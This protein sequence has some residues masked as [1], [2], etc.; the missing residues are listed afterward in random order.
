[1]KVV[2][3]VH[4]FPPSY[5]GGAEWETYRIASALQQLGHELRVICVERIDTGPT[6][7]VAWE[8]G[9]YGGIRVRRLVFNLAAMP[10]PLRGE[11]DNTWIGDHLR[12]VFDEFRPDIF[13][14]MGGYL[15]SGRAI[16][17]AN[18]LGIATVVSLMDF[19]FL[20]RRITLLRS[21]G[22]LSTLPVTSQACARCLGEERRRFRWLGQI[23]PALADVYWR[24]Q[25]AAIRHFDARAEFLLESL[26]R[27]DVIISRSQFL[28]SAFVGAGIDDEQIVLSRQGR[29]FPNLTPE[30][31]AKTP[32]PNLRIGYLGQIASHKGVH[33]LLAAARRLAG[34]PLTVRVYGDP[35][36][37]K[38]YAA[39]LRRLIADDGR[40]ELVGPCRPDDL[41]LVLRNID[42]LVVPSLWYE[43]SPNVILEAFAHGTPVI[44]SNHGGM[45]E[46][47]QA[48]VNGLLFAPGDAVSL[49]RQ[50]QRLLDEPDLLRRLRLGISPG[51]SM[52]EEIGE[53]EE[54]YRAV[55]GRPSNVPLSR[56]KIEPCVSA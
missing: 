38:A 43:N 23:A 15:I 28:R 22:Q 54:L 37:F 34:A 49:G 27:A 30:L 10:D 41:G 46:L 44:A 48:G 47:V 31:L 17:V 20:C 12:T 56:P 29:D 1:M 19:W 55:L 35:E 3:A 4:H 7:G 40:L 11:Y 6:A 39:G 26:N 45:S 24:T 53:L 14:L 13:H 9:I 25:T 42:V 52:A 36:P 8:D 33:I 32:S 18:D 16:R 5:T 21:D 50:L 51:R 2:L